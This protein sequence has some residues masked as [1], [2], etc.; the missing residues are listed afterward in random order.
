[1]VLPAFF[2]SVL[3]QNVDLLPVKSCSSQMNAHMYV[4]L[5]GD[6]KEN[7]NTVH[8]SGVKYAWWTQCKYKS[9][10]KVL[11]VTFLMFHV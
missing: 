5:T 10:L 6:E 1:M 9:E 11:Q 4:W 7:S 8:T 2:Q 3:V